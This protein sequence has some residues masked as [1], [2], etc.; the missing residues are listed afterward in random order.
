MVLQ[1]MTDI[2]CCSYGG[3]HKI[4]HG[5]NFTILVLRLIC[6]GVLHIHNIDAWLHFN[7]FYFQKL[8]LAFK[9]L[10]Q[11]CVQCRACEYFIGFNL[12]LEKRCIMFR[13]KAHHA[14]FQ[15]IVCFGCKSFLVVSFIKDAL[16]GWGMWMLFINYPWPRFPRNVGLFLLLL[17][18]ESLGELGSEAYQSHVRPQSSTSHN[19]D[20]YGSSIKEF[21]TWQRQLNQQPCERVNPLPIE[22]IVNDNVRLFRCGE[23]VTLVESWDEG[24]KGLSAMTVT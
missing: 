2:R 15:G 17:K 4:C 20:T 13:P 8:L 19:R 22:P 21:I 6:A 12:L 5:G 1:P 23:T 16:L 9:C 7:Y 11:R 24:V 18:Y 10:R 3:W 14:T